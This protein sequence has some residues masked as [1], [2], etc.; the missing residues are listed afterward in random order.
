ME[1][2]VVLPGGEDDA[3]GGVEALAEG[4]PADL[5][6]RGQ[7]AAVDRLGHLLDDRAAPLAKAS[8]QV[9]AQSRG[10]AGQRVQGQLQQLAGRVEGAL[11]IRGEVDAHGD[12]SLLGAS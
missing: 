4:H 12:V 10:L 2:A 8:H 6:D 11:A 9:G 3:Q 1:G 7:P 5:E